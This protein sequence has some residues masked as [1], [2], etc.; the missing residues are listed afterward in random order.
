MSAQAGVRIGISG[1]RYPPWRGTFYPKGLPHREELAF[2]ARHLSTIE[3]N[4][5]F[6]SLQRPE[7]YA[8][9]AAQVPPDFVF[10]VKGG[11]FITHMK[12][13]TDAEVA[14]ANF[15][16][17]GL[18][19][20]GPKL[21]PM[22]W[23]LPP[24]LAFDPDLLSAFLRALPRTTTAAAE[25]AAGHDGRLDGRALTVTDAERPIRHALEVRH[26]SFAVP[27]VVNLL[28]EHQ[29]ALVVADTAGRW[30]ALDAVTA[31]FVYVRLHGDTEL[32]VSG[33]SEDALDVWADRA[34]SWMQAGSDVWIYF[35]NDAK[36]R[37]PFDAMGLSRR[38]GVG[39]D[40]PQPVEQPR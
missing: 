12:R 2:A 10:A 36:V 31:D 6:Y 15:F 1:W 23:Q 11:R 4:G 5:S 25:L 39:P 29:V 40:L 3:I 32:Y 14:L 7:Y 28:R 30:P 37:A 26:P 17:S 24:T 13:L 20:L 38:L 16:A 18:L 21:G 35:D 34:R 27:E 9:W 19:A 8:A 33:Y 22:L